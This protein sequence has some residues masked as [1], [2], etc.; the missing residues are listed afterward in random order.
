M[1]HKCWDIF[2]SLSSDYRLWPNHSNGGVGQL[3]GGADA[4]GRALAPVWLY[5]CP[6]SPDAL[7]CWWVLH[8]FS[9]LSSNRPGV[10]FQ[11]VDSVTVGIGSHFPALYANNMTVISHLCFGKSKRWK[12]KRSS[13]VRR[14]IELRMILLRKGSIIMCGSVLILWWWLQPN[15]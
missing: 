11:P 6:H 7:Y 14:D 12:R 5:Y 8:R 10:S 3:G 9:P 13:G 2:F 15:Q 4:A 1:R